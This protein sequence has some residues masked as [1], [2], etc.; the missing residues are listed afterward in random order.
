MSYAI[1]A[2][3]SSRQAIVHTLLRS[4]RLASHVEAAFKGSQSL[5]TAMHTVC[6]YPSPP[7]VRL[8]LETPGYCGS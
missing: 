3:P 2:S 5:I 4:M 7:A 1:L 8:A 6:T